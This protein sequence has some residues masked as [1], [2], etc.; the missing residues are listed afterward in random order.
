MERRNFLFSSAALGLSMTASTV[1][2]ALAQTTKGLA[3]LQGSNKFIPPEK[4]LIPVAF[5]ISQGTT[6]I[7]WVGPE[8]VF[9]TWSLDPSRR[10]RSTIQ[11][12]YCR[13][14]TRA[15]GQFYSRLHV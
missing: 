7:D 5:V 1:S 6:D 11:A 15:D 3:L 4:G 14:K 12:L 13:R 10:S 2:K 8:A 9:E